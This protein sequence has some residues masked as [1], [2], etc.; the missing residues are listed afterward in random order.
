MSVDV[1]QSGNLE[2]RTYGAQK[3]I[4]KLLACPFCGYEFDHR[5]VRWT[6]FLEEHDPE[7]A[8]LTPLGER[9]RTDSVPDRPEETTPETSEGIS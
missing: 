7:D 6:H 3:E 2:V 5:E 1:T 8:G 4:I 9:P